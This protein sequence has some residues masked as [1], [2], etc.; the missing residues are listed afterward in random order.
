MRWDDVTGLLGMC[1]L[2]KMDL[3][4]KGEHSH[5]LFLVLVS[6]I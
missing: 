3:Y 5:S 2:D 6:M 4:Y 1:L